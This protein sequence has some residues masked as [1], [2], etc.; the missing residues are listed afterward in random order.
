VV[1]VT[2]SARG[3]VCAKGEV[4]TVRAP[5]HLMSTPA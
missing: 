5:E 4:I 1:A 3:E 2:L